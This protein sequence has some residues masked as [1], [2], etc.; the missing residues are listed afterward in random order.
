MRKNK[1]IYAKNKIQKKREADL[2]ITKTIVLIKSKKK[3]ES[4]WNCARRALRRALRRTRIWFGRITEWF[5]N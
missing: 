3:I 5:G 1:N 4:D 2:F